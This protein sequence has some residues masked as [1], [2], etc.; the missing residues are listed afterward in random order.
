MSK[1]TIEKYFSFFIFLGFLFYLAISFTSSLIYSQT[2]LS[3]SLN[4]NYTI[5]NITL[6]TSYI[7]SYI[8]R[9]INFSNFNG[10]NISEFKNLSFLKNIKN[11]TSLFNTNTLNYN[12]ISG[13]INSNIINY[14]LFCTNCINTTNINSL[15]TTGLNITNIEEIIKKNNINNNINVSVFN[16]IGFG[17]NSINYKNYN[18]SN[19]SFIIPI[20]NIKFIRNFSSRFNSIIQNK[21]LLANLISS[22]ATFIRSI[23]YNYTPRGFAL[24]NSTIQNIRNGNSSITSWSMIGNVSN[25]YINAQSLKSVVS[26]INIT[27]SNNSYQNVYENLFLNYLKNKNNTKL[28]SYQLI[29]AVSNITGNNEI[30]KYIPSNITVFQ[31]ESG[32]TL[33]EISKIESNISAHIF[34]KNKNLVIKNITINPKESTKEITSLV[35]ELNSSAFGKMVPNAAEAAANSINPITYLYINSTL[36]DSAI[37]Y[38]NYT[39]NITKNFL[40]EH[41]INPSYI[42]LFRYYALNNTWIKLPTKI[43]GENLTNYIYRSE[44]PGMSIYA[45]GYEAP[46]QQQIP[47]I[48]SSALNETASASNENSLYTVIAIIAIILGLILVAYIIKNARRNKNQ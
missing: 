2:N 35:Q 1:T 37:N 29:Y 19:I 48:T 45:V 38:V 24:I 21:T 8:N 13:L 41:G 5:K 32:T 26:N 17:S 11:Y 14:N 22:N 46:S 47:N 3:N 42:S 23:A 44:S 33:L 34:I 12:I 27:A 20:N 10:I 28:E 15:N 25:E 36:P 18:L 7:N 16:G 30:I 9:F 40:E 39:F 43:I 31:D 6:N 4:A